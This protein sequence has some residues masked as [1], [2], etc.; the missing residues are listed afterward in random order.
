MAAPIPSQHRNHFLVSGNPKESMC[1]CKRI[2]SV[3]I[4]R[5]SFR[6]F[7]YSQPLLNPAPT[8]TLGR[9]QVVGLSLGTY[10][11]ISFCGEGTGISYLSCSPSC[12]QQLLN[13]DTFHSQFHLTRGSNSV[14]LPKIFIT[15]SQSVI[16]IYTWV[17][18]F[19]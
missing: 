16:L 13:A 11:L 6:S 8:S 9:Q 15:D 4:R 18:S 5:F 2:Y 7:L 1:V 12:L 17:F 10:L 14:F 19:M 3:N